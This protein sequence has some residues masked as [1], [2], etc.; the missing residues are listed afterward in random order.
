LQ[1]KTSNCKVNGYWIIYINVWALIDLCIPK[2]TLMMRVF[3]RFQSTV[4]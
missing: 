1:V 3:G 4:P 2:I